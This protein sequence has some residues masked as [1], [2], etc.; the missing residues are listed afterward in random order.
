VPSP[1][2]INPIEQS[3][4]CLRL[5]ARYRHQEHADICCDAKCRTRT[6]TTIPI[7]FV[8][9]GDP[10]QQGIVASLNQPGGN[11]TGVTWLGNLLRDTSRIDSQRNF[12]C[13]VGE[14]GQSEF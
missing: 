3:P 9:G 7:V 13:R 5:A 8:T 10:V 2:A 12:I 1:R 6:L 11:I 4:Q 14:S